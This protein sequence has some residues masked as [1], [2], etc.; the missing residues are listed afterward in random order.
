LPGVYYIEL[1]KHDPVTGIGEFYVDSLMDVRHEQVTMHTPEEGQL[2]RVPLSG[3]LSLYKYPQG[4]L[5]FEGVNYESGGE[6]QILL[7]TPLDQGQY[8]AADYRYPAASTGP[9]PF[10]EMRANKSA[11]PGVV[12]AFGRL[13]KEGDRAAIVVQPR[14]EAA[15]QEYGGRW[16]VSLDFDII[17][18]DLYSQQ[19]IADRTIVWVWGNMRGRVSEEGVE[20]LDVSLGGE[21][22]EIYDENA[23]DYFYN[24]SFSVTCETEWS[25]HVPLGP[26][27]RSV[28]LAT[29]AQLAAAVEDPGAYQEGT[30]TAGLGVQR[31]Q[32]PFLVGRSRTFEVIR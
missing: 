14:R 6:G 29:P 13:A 5:L 15:Y 7:D 22:E 20:I 17:A 18:R 11:I 24:A 32:D 1:T 8:I 19:E 3:T 10:C 9:H 16:Q 28:T 4:A 12:L 21:T 23:D 27:L 30:V 31:S 25:I 2:Q 26:Q